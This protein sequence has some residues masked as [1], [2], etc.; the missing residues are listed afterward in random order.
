MSQDWFRKTSWTS[1]DSEDFFARLKRSREYNRSQ[2]LRIQASHLADVGTH[3]L[4]LSA[5]SLLEILLENYPDRFQMACAYLQKAE[6]L[7]SLGRIEESIKYFKQSIDY[8][9]TFPNVSN[10]A[11]ISFGL[12]VVKNNYTSEY[13]SVLDTLREFEEKIS[14]FPVDRFRISGIR[15]IIAYELGEHESAREFAQRAISEAK[16]GHSGFW[17]H[18]KLGLVDENDHIFREMLKRSLVRL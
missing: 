18:S 12:L 11:A 16:R 9:R 6:C 3:E 4:T 8:Q 13:K 10:Q 1:S 14:T 5:L 17:K 7:S 2:Y 15:A